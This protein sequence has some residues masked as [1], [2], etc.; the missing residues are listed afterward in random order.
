MGLFPY[1]VFPLAAGQTWSSTACETSSSDAVCLKLRLFHPPS[2][3]WWFGKSQYSK[4]K[5]NKK[6]KHAH[7]KNKHE[8]YNTNATMTQWVWD[9][10]IE[11]YSSAAAALTVSPITLKSPLTKITPKTLTRTFLLL[12]QKCERQS[13]SSVW[14]KKERKTTRQCYRA[15]DMCDSP[16]TSVLM[17]FTNQQEP[18]PHFKCYYTVISREIS[19]ETHTCSSSRPHCSS[20]TCLVSMLVPQ[21]PVPHAGSH[22]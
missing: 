17:R 22:E 2:A 15:R 9:R 12:W 20:T 5:Q 3:R 8:N 11:T 6:K 16:I 1:A 21:T 7:E 14:K 13:K 19:G 10:Y 18:H 4:K